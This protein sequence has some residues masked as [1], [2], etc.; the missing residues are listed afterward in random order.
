M[1]LCVGVPEITSS[2]V[3]IELTAGDTLRLHCSISASLQAYSTVWWLHNALPLS[4]TQPLHLTGILQ[5]LSLVYLLLTSAQT[6]FH[7]SFSSQLMVRR[8]CR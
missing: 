8:Q 4:T 5:Q 6:E 3:D 2:P 1:T 7:S